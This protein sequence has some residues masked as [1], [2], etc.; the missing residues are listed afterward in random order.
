MYI[1]K[2]S[3]TGV[4]LYETGNRRETGFSGGG[5]VLL[6]LMRAV[7]VWL[8]AAA[9]QRAFLSV[10]TIPV[11]ER[12]MYGFLL[13]FSVLASLWAAGPRKVRFISFLAFTGAAAVLFWKKK[14][15]AAAMVNTIA[16]A[17]LRVHDEE[18]VSLQLYK[19]PA[20]SEWMLG[21]LTAFAIVPLLLLWCYVITRNRGRVLAFAAILFPA[22]LSAVEGYFI[23]M[24]SCWLLLFGA[25]MYFAVCGGNSGKT[26]AKSGVSAFVCIFLLFLIGS[27]AVKPVESMKR[28]ED[29]FYLK[30]RSAVTENVIQ[31]VADLTGSAEKEKDA[32][33]KEETDEKARKEQKTKEDTSKEPESEEEVADLEKQEKDARTPA[34]P[35]DLDGSTGGVSGAQDLK[36]IAAFS[37]GDGKGITVTVKEQP[38]GTYYYPEEY[39]GGYDGNSWSPMPLG[40]EVYPEYSEYPGNLGELVSLCRK[41]KVDNI[42]DA[43]R[44]IQQLFEKQTVYDYQP[45][46]TPKDQDF[47]EYFLFENKKGFCV[48]FA[49]TAT[50]MYRIFG[51]QARYAQGFAIPASAFQKQPDG[52][53]TAQVTGDMGHAWCETYDDGWTIREH[54]LPYTGDEPQA[55]PPAQNSS[56]NP[57]IK[58]SPVKKVLVGIL[59]GAGSLVIL[60]G[61]FFFQSALRRKQRFLRCRKYRQGRGILELYQSLYDIAVFLGMEKMDPADAQTFQSLPE[62]IPNISKQDWEWIHMIVW[63]T[64]FGPSCPSKAEH[65]KLFRIVFDTAEQTGKMQ[66]GWK[67]FK[68]RYLNNLG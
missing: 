5:S 64:L 57:P 39:G 14:A 30:A 66:T 10:F 7:F 42:E 20:V 49:T 65:E 27:A 2:K 36:S 19:V 17:Y 60:V 25:G 33:K 31:R 15:L 62:W 32:Q 29:G 8:L 46:P 48:H 56:E 4:R 23:S 45:G 28:S 37:P 44:F 63:Q 16:N 50:L 40:E 55:L 35:S 47:S 1:R 59:A 3:R 34:P 51:F 12:W 11:K 13:L 58:E 43:A 68:Y 53:Y 9:W 67:R 21:F 24:Q 52:T 61:V 18:A 54:T 41:Q 6:I 38:K 26:A 22:V